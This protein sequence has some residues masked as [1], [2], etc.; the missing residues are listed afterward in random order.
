MISIRISSL[1]AGIFLAFS[2][3]ATPTVAQISDSRITQEA[4]QKVLKDIVCATCLPYAQLE[5]PVGGDYWL[6]RDSYGDFIALR[7]NS[8]QRVKNSAMSTE[9]AISYPYK[10]GDTLRYSWRMRLPGDFASDYP[11]N[12][13]WL[14]ARWNDQ[15]NPKLG[16]KPED[17]LS[18]NPAMMVGYKQ[19]DS[20]DMLNF[21]YG[22]PDTIKTEAFGIRRGDWI[23]LT[24]EVTW[25]RT[26][27]G[28]AKLFV[29][30]SKQPLRVVS[31]PNMYSKHLNILRLGMSRSVDI[32]TST[33]IQIGDVEIERVKAAAKP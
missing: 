33:Y 23:K 9:L 15:A 22:V 25:S 16:E 20:Q 26:E 12:H 2:G 28:E 30:D 17:F 6:G 10:E 31:G 4:S 7:V 27:K 32:R 11:Y 13:W 1:Y 29:N 3:V 21:S 18:H 8:Y 14:F 19:A 5:V 24:A